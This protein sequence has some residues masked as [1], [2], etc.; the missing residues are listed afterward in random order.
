MAKIILAIANYGGGY[1][2]VGVSEKD[3]EFQP[4][5][6]EKLA[7]KADIYKDIENYIPE[8][9]LQTLKIENFSY[10]ES[11]LEKL[12]GKKF[13]V[14]IIHSNDNQLPYLSLKEGEGLYKNRIY[15]RRG[16]NNVEANNEEVNTILERK[17]KSIY[18]TRK[19]L[20]LE[21]H[22]SQLK[23]LYQHTSKTRTV[24]VGGIAQRISRKMQNSLSG[25]AGY[26]E[27]RDN[28][29]YPKLSF[30]EFIKIC[31]EDKQG[32]IREELDI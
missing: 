19:Q 29:N 15:T 13:Q 23:E 4:T 6:L 27:E 18:S 28:I 26:E 20:D 30:E 2:I 7:D 21:V 14:M 1:I 25:I 17:L 31:I 9:L 32:R 8:N 3:D 5:G 16:S 22:L 24:R 10:T 12:K 11:E